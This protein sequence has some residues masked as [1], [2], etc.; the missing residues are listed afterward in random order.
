MHEREQD[1]NED[2]CSRSG[3][4]SWAFPTG[5]RRYGVSQ[6]WTSV[7]GQ[8]G[9]LRESD[10]A[11]PANQERQ[12]A[13]PPVPL[14]RSAAAMRASPPARPA[15]NVTAPVYAMRRLD[16]VPTRLPATA[17]LVTTATPARR[18][19][20]ASVEAA[21]G[22]T[23]SSAMLPINVTTRGYATGA[24]SCSDPTKSNG[25]PCDADAMRARSATAVR[26]ESARCSAP[27]CQFVM[28]AARRLPA[29]G[30]Y[31]NCAPAAAT[32][33]AARPA[34]RRRRRV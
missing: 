13:A 18:R 33:P 9:L 4:Y 15:T 11:S 25:T 22:A 32:A 21:R 31:P 17:R 1:E 19:T 28:R 20:R 26:M 6:P 27:T 16:D 29:C 34:S 10:S 12:S 5:R 2:P 7:R 14:D 24:R 23:R 8:P 3:R 30:C